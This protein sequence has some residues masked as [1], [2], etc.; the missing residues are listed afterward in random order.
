[1]LFR[2]LPLVAIMLLAQSARIRREETLLA[3]RFGDAWRAY[4]SRTGALWPRLGGA[5][6]P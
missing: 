2:S 4:T 5:P 3:E 6:R 1:M